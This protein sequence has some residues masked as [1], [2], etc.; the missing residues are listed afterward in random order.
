MKTI[1]TII[2]LSLATA[3]S[4]NAQVNKKATKSETQTSKVQPPQDMNKQIQNQTER[5]TEELDLSPEQVDQ[6]MSENKTLYSNMSSLTTEKVSSEDY[7]K[8]SSKTIAN[9]DSNLKNILDESQ[10]QTYQNMK[11]KYMKDFNLPKASE[12]KN[13]EAMG[14]E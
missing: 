14:Y 7:K 10:Y 5:M 1:V 12:A 6:V 9:Y 11:S 3:F 8:M 4:V 2:A 13:K